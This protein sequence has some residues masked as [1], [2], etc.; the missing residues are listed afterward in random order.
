MVWSS[1]LYS[2]SGGSCC[3]CCWSCCLSLRAPL[4]AKLPPPPPPLVPRLDRLPD[5]L[6]APPLLRKGLPCR[7]LGLLAACAMPAPDLAAALR[8]CCSSAANLVGQSGAGRAG[9][10]VFSSGR[11]VVFLYILR[12]TSC[13]SRS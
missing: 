9:A 10:A 11:A 13:A 2:G 6:P 12:R 4:P 7:E 1:R 8:A 5:L 3:C